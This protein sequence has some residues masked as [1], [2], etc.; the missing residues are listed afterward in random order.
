MSLAT[1]MRMARKNGASPLRFSRLQAIKQMLLVTARAMGSSSP[2][3]VL[4]NFVKL[5][6]NASPQLKFAILFLTPWAML[7]TAMSRYTLLRQG[8]SAVKQYAKGIIYASVSIPGSHPLNKQLLQFMVEQQGLGKNARTLALSPPAGTN[9]LGSRGIISMFDDY[10]YTYD[11]TGRRARNKRHPNAEEED[12][13][14]QALSFIPEVGSYSKCI[15]GKKSNKHQGSAVWRLAMT[16][17]MFSPHMCCL[18][19][20]LTVDFQPS[21]INGTQ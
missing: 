5:L 16:Q 7:I 21:G 8:L 11:A 3:N 2:E 1:P 15:D 4:E 9:P 18:R 20:L 13:Q 10:P 14:R 6:Q 12:R 17:L 19:R